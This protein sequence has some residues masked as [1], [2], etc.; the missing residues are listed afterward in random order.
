MYHK[1]IIF[2]AKI[3]NFFKNYLMMMTDEKKNGNEL[4]EDSQIKMKKTYVEPSQ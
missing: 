4:M 3:L 2:M 1:D